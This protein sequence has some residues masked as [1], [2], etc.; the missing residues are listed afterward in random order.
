MAVV[1]LHR[2]ILITVV[3]RD[4]VMV[5]VPLRRSVSVIAVVGDGVTVVV[6]LRRPVSVTAVDGGVFRAC[7]SLFYLALVITWP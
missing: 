1:P 7:R 4:R 2:S 6:P 5:V 3:M